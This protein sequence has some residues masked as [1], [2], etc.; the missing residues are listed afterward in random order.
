MITKKLNTMKFLR[1]T[2]SILFSALLGYNSTA[3]GVPSRDVQLNLVSLKNDGVVGGELQF[4][5][6]IRSTGSSF[7][8]GTSNIN[9]THDAATV[10]FKNIVPLNFTSGPY[11]PMTATYDS[12]VFYRV[13]IIIDLDQVGNG[14][15]V[16]DSTGWTDVATVTFEILSEATDLSLRFEYMGAIPLFGRTVIRED[17]NSTFKYGTE[18]DTFDRIFYSDTNTV[19]IPGN[20]TWRGGNGPNGSPDATDGVKQIVVNSGIA[21]ITGQMQCDYFSAPNLGATVVSLLLMPQLALTYRE[22]QVISLVVPMRLLL[23]LMPRVMANTSVPVLKPQSSNTLARIPD[24]AI[25]VSRLMAMVLI[26][27]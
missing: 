17:D 21:V 2:L 14:D 15:P 10:T 25:S 7:D 5:V 22:V 3:Q 18:E 8:L 6:Q 27:M 12:T 24:G 13:S 26:L 9:F 19:I 20:G 16:S 1:F 11:N 4:K 23:T